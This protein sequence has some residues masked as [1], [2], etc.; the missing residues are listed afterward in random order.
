YL[1]RHNEI[2]DPPRDLIGHLPGVRTVEM[3]RHRERGLCCGA[4]GAR[5]WVEERIGK[6]INAERVDEAVSTGADQVGVA[7]PYC[8]IMPDDGARDR[9]VGPEVLDVAQALLRSL[10]DRASEGR[11]RPD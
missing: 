11:V 9:V 1:G 4:G 6:R 10:P 5:M 3:P 7:C 2:Y 8:L